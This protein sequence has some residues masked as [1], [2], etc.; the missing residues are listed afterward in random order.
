MPS[1][2]QQ[3]SM[4]PGGPQTGSMVLI[5]QELD[6]LAKLL[7]LDLQTSPNITNHIVPCLLYSAQ[8][9]EQIQPSQLGM[10]WMSYDVFCDFEI[11][12]TVQIL[13][14]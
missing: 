11:I 4:F 8:F 14:Q 13:N 9:Q 1:N 7:N 5:D 10:I 2:P 6:D 3:C 12:P